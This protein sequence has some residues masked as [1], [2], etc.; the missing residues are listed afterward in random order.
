MHDAWHDASRETRQ[1]GLVAEFNERMREARRKAGFS[2]QTARDAVNPLLTRPLPDPG[3]IHRIE[4]DPDAEDKASVEL[5]VHL[6]TVYGVDPWSMS[7][8]IM[9]AWKRSIEATPEEVLLVRNASS[10]KPT[11]RKRATRRYDQ[12]VPA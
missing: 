7:V 3:K 8:S 2:L 6:C 9:Q 10:I 1:E 5:V 11:T 12:L 4:V